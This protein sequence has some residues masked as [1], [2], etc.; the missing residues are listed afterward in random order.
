MVSG[1]RLLS[2]VYE[3]ELGCEGRILRCP[4]HGWEFDLTN[5]KHLADPNVKLRGFEVLVEVGELYI[6][7]AS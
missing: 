4:W 7:L 5:G 6:M 3:Y 1:T 2:N